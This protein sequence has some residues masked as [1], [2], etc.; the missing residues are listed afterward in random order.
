MVVAILDID[1]HE[2]L[3]D[4]KTIISRAYIALL[5]DSRWLFIITLPFYLC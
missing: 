4:R 1:D 2:T 3:S 5:L